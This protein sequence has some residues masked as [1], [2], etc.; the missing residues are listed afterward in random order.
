[1]VGGGVGGMRP[2]SFWNLDRRRLASCCSCGDTEDLESFLSSRPRQGRGS[3]VGPT[4]KLA[5]WEVGAESRLCLWHTSSA[6]R[7]SPATPL[8]G[9][10]VGRAANCGE[11]WA[12]D[13]SA[14]MPLFG[15][16]VVRS[17]FALLLS[18]FSRFVY[19]ASQRVNQFLC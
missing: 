16:R 18:L 12:S 3:A 7:P 5:E 19:E 14:A 8:F 9:A 13:V 2:F 17:S 4:A 1:M 10:R 11:R 15:G 6:R